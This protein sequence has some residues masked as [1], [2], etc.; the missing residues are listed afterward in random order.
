M[1]AAF[2]F[3]LVMLAASPAAAQ[4]LVQLPLFS[5]TLVLQG[6][7]GVTSSTLQPDTAEVSFWR[8][9]TLYDDDEPVGG[10]MDCRLAGVVQPYT[11]ELFDIAARYEASKTRRDYAGL[12]DDGDPDY[13]E[14]GL[15]RRLQVTGRSNDPHHHYVLTFLAIHA[16]EALYDIRI[17]CEFRHLHSPD[18]DTDYAAIQARYVDLAIPVPAASQEGQ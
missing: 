9:V 5:D 1:K 10:R 16:G 18:N 14:D 4:E 3:P 8:P 11:D 12:D 15:V 2:A 17:N 6:E 13:S 7:F